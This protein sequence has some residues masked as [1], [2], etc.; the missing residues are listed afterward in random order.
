MMKTIRRHTITLLVALLALL[1]IAYRVFPNMS[2][3]V[4]LFIG[5]LIALL[6]GFIQHYRSV[7][8]H[9]KLEEKR[10]VIFGSVFHGV[11]AELRH[12]DPT[13]RFLIMEIEY[14]GLDRWSV[15]R[16][17]FGRNMGTDPDKDLGLRLSQGVS[18]QAVAQRG[19]CV[20]DLEAAHGPT[21]NLDQDQ[22]E[23]TKDLTLVLSMPIK[24]TKKLP[25]DTYILTDDIIGVA[26]IDSKKK[27]AYEYYLNTILYEA[28]SDDEGQSLLEA[29]F[30]NL[31]EISQLCSYILS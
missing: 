3:W 19:F 5:L 9:L 31:Q 23:K 14:R 30:R 12:H 28:D 13:A 21:F 10:T 6:A 17:V 2:V 22:L 20:A 16:H 29:Q 4:Q 18:G 8:P 25:D 15:F 7:R 24:R 11:L 1:P 26:N 27:G